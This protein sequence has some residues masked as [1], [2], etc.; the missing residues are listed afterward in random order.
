M[1][2]QHQKV[3][4]ISKILSNGIIG[5]VIYSAIN[6]GILDMIYQKKDTTL[7][8]IAKQNIICERSLYRVVKFL[9]CFK[10]VVVNDNG[11]C[12]LTELG[13]HLLSDHPCKISDWILF[14]GYP[15]HQALWFNISETISTGKSITEILYN[16]PYFQWISEDKT[17][18]ELFDNAM[19]YLGQQVNLHVVDAFDFSRASTIVDLGAG[20]G[21]QLCHIVENNSHLQGILFDQKFTIENAKKNLLSKPYA[22]RLQFHS[23]DFFTSIPSGNDIYILKSVLQDWDDDQV[24]EILTL[25]KKAM[26]ADSKLLIIESLLNETSDPDHSNFLDIYMLV[27]TGGMKRTRLDFE[28]LINKSGLCLLNMVDTI[29]PTKEKILI[30]CKK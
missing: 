11:I 26:H 6:L 13:K 29:S 30:C 19:R 10:F 12:Q 25:C 2:T 28:T 15:R 22:M 5:K 4:E 1:N 24:L 16:K 18:Q 20:T 27:L 23:G 7:E 14:T 3:E 17:G 8:E 9:A 21:E